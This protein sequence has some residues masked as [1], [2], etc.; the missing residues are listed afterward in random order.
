M[1][2]VTLVHVKPEIVVYGGHETNKST[3]PPWDLPL[4]SQQRL[5]SACLHHD[6]VQ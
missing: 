6:V 2:I 4:R 5:S 3:N 1:L